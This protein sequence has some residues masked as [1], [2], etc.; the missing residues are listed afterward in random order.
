MVSLDRTARVGFIGAGRVGGSLAVAMTAAGYDVVGVASRTYAS[1]GAFAARIS[2]CTAYAHSQDVVD[3]SDMVFIT[4]PDDVIACAAAAVRWRSGQG[5][6]H[7]SGV[8]S[9]DVLD[10][11]ALQGT[12]VGGFHPLQAFSSVENGSKSIRGS[13]FGIEGK[14]EMRA[15]LTALAQDVGGNAVFLNAEDK[16]LYHVSGMLMGNLLTCL[17]GISG[18]VWER[19]GYTRGDGVRALVP[20]M[21]A[22]ADNIE[23][24]G[25]PAAV[26]GPYP[27][28][29]I[30]TIQKHLDAL[31]ERHPRLLPLYRELALA[32]LPLAME[33]GLPPDTA[34]TLRRMLH[35]Q[36]ASSGNTAILRS[37]IS[38]VRD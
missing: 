6:A 18:E 38:T 14:S 21:R 35:E 12:L 2:G 27:R 37:E 15:Y 34:D 28:G 16:V 30:G 17:V 8:S 24:S 22:I 31:S 32:G 4:T 3:A 20:M 13:T 33:Q 7:C 1:A 10:A 19:I 5:V 9:L 25:I 11:A 23:T 29:D 26:A 36:E